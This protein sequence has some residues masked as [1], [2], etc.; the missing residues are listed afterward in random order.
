[1]HRDKVYGIK[2]NPT[3]E[4]GGIARTFDAVGLSYRQQTGEDVALSD[5]DK[6]Y[7]WSEIKE[8]MICSD[9]TVS[10]SYSKDFLKEGNIFRD[11]L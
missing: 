6:C 1:M 8:C 4:N 2:F 7:P 11:V 5:F 9:G 3:K 10:Y